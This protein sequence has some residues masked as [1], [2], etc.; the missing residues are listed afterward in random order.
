M[1][2]SGKRAFKQ[3]SAT[4][5][6]RFWR[7]MKRVLRH[8]LSRFREFFASLLPSP[9]LCAY[10]ALGAVLWLVAAFVPAFRLL[11]VFYNL[12]LAILALCDLIFS[13]QPRDFEVWR[14]FTAK[15]NLGTRNDIALCARSRARFA[16]SLQIR[17]ETPLDWPVSLPDSPSSPGNVLPTIAKIALRLEA[18]QSARG[19]Y[20][21][22]PSR[23]GDFEFGRLHTRYASV[24]GMWFRQF[25]RESEK[26]AQVYPDLSPV[27]RY[28]IALREGKMRDIGL[29]LLR[30]RGRGT[31]FESLREYTSG[32]EYKSINWKASARSGKL[33]S[34]SYEIE[35]D[36]TM[37]I[38]LDCGRMMTSMAV[39]KDDK[40]ASEDEILAGAPQTALSKLDCAINATVLLAHVAASMNDAVGLLLFSDGVVKWLP[41]RK[42]RVQTGLIIEALYGAQPSLVEP[43]YQVAYEHLMARRVRRALVVTFTDIIDTSASRELLSASGALRK[44]HNAL[45]VTIANRDVSEMA[46]QFP[47]NEDALYQKAMAQRMLSEREGALEKLRASGVGILDV[48]ANELTVATVNRYLN[49]KSRGAL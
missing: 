12:V 41:P 49:L 45:C 11:V 44:H 29:H 2:L 17:D 13:P 8:L 9:R 5:R 23:R 27:R 25:T 4:K 30:L 6:A 32:D 15:M 48:E 1:W 26:S 38:C 47:Q 36:Q 18:G 34:T 39:S 35:R 37:V 46:A 3:K 16:V 19:T 20:G 40:R 31:E 14:E 22:T 43:D 10:I 28:E 33:I 21:L 42:G 24:L 7:K